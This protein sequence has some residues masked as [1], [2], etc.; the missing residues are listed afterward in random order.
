MSL[1]DLEPREKKFLAIGLAV[2]AAVILYLVFDLGSGSGGASMSRNNALRLQAEFNAD[3]EQYREMAPVVEEIDRK[4]D[5]NPEG[6]DLYT[7]LTKIVDEVGLQIKNM[8]KNQ[9]SSSEFYSEE[10]VDMDIKDAKLDDLVSLLQKIEDSPAFLRV[11]KLSVKRKRGDDPAID[12]NLRVSLY[13]R[14]QEQE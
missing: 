13:T 3:L 12:I 7:E 8:N 14:S 5:A 9:G 11:P 1:K 4:L 2:A 6:Y 10:Y